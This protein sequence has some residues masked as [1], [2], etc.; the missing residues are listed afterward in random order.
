MVLAEACGMARA[1]VEIVGSGSLS[2]PLGASGTLH[3]EVPWHRHWPHWLVGGLVALMI[4]ALGASIESHRVP[5]AKGAPVLLLAPVSK[6]GVLEKVTARGELGPPSEISVAVPQ[7]G[8]VV[9]LAVAPG[10]TVR[11]GQILARLDPLAA[12]S[13]VTRAEAAVVAAEVA[14]LEAELRLARLRRA[15]DRGVESEE[16]GQTLVENTLAAEARLAR[17][18]AEV[19]AREAELRVAR[20][21]AQHTSV[22]SPI[23]GVVTARAVAVEQTL[24][25]GAVMYRVA[26]AGEPLHLVAQVEEGELGK[27]VP[28]QRVRFSVPAYPGETFTGEVERSGAIAIAPDGLRRGA[29]AIVVH[30][31]RGRLRP[32]MSAQ[33]QIEVRSAAGAWRVPVAALQFS[34]DRLPSDGNQSGIWLRQGTTLRRISAEVRASDGVYAEVLA[35]GLAEGAGVAVGYAQTRSD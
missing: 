8:R 30:D 4:G 10:Q 6:G 33:V 3:G 13:A 5:L 9:E 12:R 35:P 24:E 11:R 17:A 20:Q 19:D 34:P 32:G 29:I 15:G 27:V 14:A 26:P 18:T 21:Q 1:H 16:A 7:A 25:A 31:D 23:D 22:R 2:S 28:G